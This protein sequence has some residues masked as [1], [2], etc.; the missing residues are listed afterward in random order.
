MK[1]KGATDETLNERL[2]FIKLDASGSEQIRGLKSI[3]AR[4]LP[5]GLD[6]FYAQVRATEAVRRH[7][8]GEDHIAAAKRAQ[9]KHWNAIGAGVFDASYSAAVRAIGKAH[10]NVGLEPRWY[11]GGYALIVEQLINAVVAEVWP[12]D[13]FR[14]RKSAEAEK[15][16]AALGSL[17]KAVFLDIDLAISTYIDAGAEMQAKMAAERERA[18]T[19]QSLAIER[20]AAALEKLAAKDLAS[21]IVD[22]MPESFLRLKTDFNSAIDQLAAAFKEVSASASGVRSRA[23]EISTASNNLSRRAEQQASSLEQTAAAL[24][25]ITAASGDT[26]EGA[27]HANKVVA[28]A[29][30]DA[31]QSIEIVRQA[32]DAM[33][34]I[35]R[36]S[37]QI[38]RIIGVIDEIAFQTNL[39][40]LNAGVEA[41][42]AGDAGRG[43]AVVA[44]EVR[45]LAQRSAEAAREIKG[46]IHA[47]TTHV[48]EGVALVGK[49]GAALERIETKVSE[50]NDVIAKIASSVKEQA[51]G[52]G[53]IN[54]TVNQMDQ[55]TQR[56]AALAEEMSATSRSLSAESERLSD[57]IGQFRFGDRTAGVLRRE[58][59][60]VAPHA[61]AQSAMQQSADAE[62]RGSSIESK[63]VEPASAAASSRQNAKAKA[64]NDSW[65][66]F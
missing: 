1:V 49:T 60:S 26:D 29:R 27:R 6:K 43:F 3:I 56:N 51:S 31:R 61:F 58:L 52:L 55:V 19:E 32:I 59:K 15:I 20:L 54:G 25:E 50:I 30:D 13:I 47:S 17:V 11:I 36:S 8:S 44:S 9:I 41:A 45:A 2:R 4:E 24:N 33:G 40:A 10:A 62:R 46:L 22:R 14:M 28:V 38:G 53:E 63:S 57:L 21:Q 34:K 37:T 35:E 64:A 42:R 12:K 18:A 5:R 48:S 65:E 23:E 7:F 66:E 16:G 39:L